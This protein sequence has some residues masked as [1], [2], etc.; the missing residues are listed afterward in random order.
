MRMRFMVTL[1][2]REATL[3]QLGSRDA[4]VRPMTGSVST[5]LQH[6]SQVRNVGDGDHVMLWRNRIGS[7]D[8]CGVPARDSAVSG[9][10]GGTAR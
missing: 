1:P 10:V 5:P 9:V 3:A 8:G 6:V 4:G 2:V 7:G